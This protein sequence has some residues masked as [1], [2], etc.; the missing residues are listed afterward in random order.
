MSRRMRLGCAVLLGATC[1]LHLSARA[2]GRQVF[3]QTCAACHLGGMGGAPGINDRENWR[4]RLE[5]GRP[6]L[7]SHALE[8]IR[9]MPARGG[10]ATLSDA[11]I[12]AAVDY[13]ISRSRAARKE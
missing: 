5:Q 8:G 11:Q 13:M 12:Q 10:N 2:Q 1:L 9:A 7:I 6:V 4:K 3:D